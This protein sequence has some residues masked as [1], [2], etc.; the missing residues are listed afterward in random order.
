MK[1]LILL[2]SILI[3]SNCTF[4]FGNPMKSILAPI[5]SIAS[6]N[7]KDTEITNIQLPNLDINELYQIDSLPFQIDSTIPK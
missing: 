7:Q 6:I 5:D 3:L 1:H 4:N 2:L